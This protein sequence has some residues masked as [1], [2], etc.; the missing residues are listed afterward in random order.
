ML[1]DLGR[2]LCKFAAVIV[3]E[4]TSLPHV[5]LEEVCAT[6]GVFQMVS[7]AVPGHICEENRWTAEQFGGKTPASGKK[8]PLKTMQP[9]ECL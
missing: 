6:H 5:I 4:S 7:L 1:K 9:Q 2:F 3:E 8:N